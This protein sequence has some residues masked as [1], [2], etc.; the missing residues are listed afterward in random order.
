MAARGSRAGPNKKAARKVGKS[1]NFDKSEDGI[2]KKA[3]EAY[4]LQAL[5]RRAFNAKE[6][7]IREKQISGPLK[8]IGIK[9][10]YAEYVF[11]NFMMETSG[12]DDAVE[13][14]ASDRALSLVTQRRIHAALHDGEQLDWD[15]LQ[16]QHDKAVAEG[17]AAAGT[18]VEETDSKGE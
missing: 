6:K 7:E 16:K 8:T 17:E 15:K 5:R 14:A 13:K 3:A 1:D 9:M 2:I 11:D 18:A 10:K 4:K 12:E